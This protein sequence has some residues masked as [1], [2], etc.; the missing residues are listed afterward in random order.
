M[1]RLMFILAW[2]MLAATAVAQQQSIVNS[3][4]NL[5]ANG[6]GAVRA[7]NEQEVCIFCH[8]PHNAAP[9]QPLWNRN[10]PAS[11]Y[12]VYSSNSLQAAPGQPTGSSKLC[13]SCHDGTIALGSVLSREQPIA[14]AG[15]ITTLPPGTTNLGTDLSD[16]HPIS[17]KYDAALTQKNLKLKDP[18]LLPPDVK[19]DANKEIQ[20]TSCHNAHDNQFG[21]FLVMDNTHSAL[22]SSCHSNGTTSV[23]GHSECANCHQQHSAPSGPYLLKAAKVS[24]TCLTCHSGTGGANQGADIASDINKYSK[25]DT[26]S[27]VNLAD[28]YPNNVGCSDCH[29]PH[30]MTGVI[31]S[32][33]SISGK[34]G[35][36]NG[37]NAS[38][39]PVVNAQYEYEVCF[40]CHADKSAVPPTVSR[41]VVQ[42]NLRLKFDPTAVSFHPVEAAGR[43][44]NVPSLRPGLSTAS[45]IYCNDCHNSDTGKKAGTGG[46]DGVHGSINKPLLVARYDTL[47][48][49]PESE[50]TY[51]LCYKC[52]D[53]NNILANASFTKHKEHVVDKR[54][55]CSTCHDPHGIP[56]AQGTATTNA[57]LINFDTSIVQRDPV[58]QKLE[59]RSTG[60]GHG[61]CTLSCHGVVHS[62]TAY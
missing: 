24:D 52:H 4:H 53:R 11:T 2:W 55:T 12:R 14:M 20:C 31:A 33:P 8:T 32:A 17:F 19:L 21:K 10:T 48:N 25:H 41:Q 40:K 23:V 3:P 47:D 38:G 28:P 60:P 30:T 13:L 34:F 18:A 45:I 50:A 27:P 39:V 29:E 49:T 37:V 44:T 51:A 9:V 59:Y 36:I 16:D 56:S 35:K 58:T 62:G 42:A 6:P 54:T 7:S 5:S 1:K 46:P 22:C 43:N 15:G 61:T 26:S 57:N